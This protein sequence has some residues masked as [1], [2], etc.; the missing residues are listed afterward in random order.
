MKK[1]AIFLMTTILC[2]AFWNSNSYA[3]KGKP[4]LPYG[5]YSV[6]K[7][8][9][10]ALGDSKKSQEFRRLLIPLVQ[11]KMNQCGYSFTLKESDI[12]WIFDQVKEQEVWLES[13]Q[14]S[15]SR[16]LESSQKIE[17][18]VS[19]SRY[20][21]NAGVFVYENCSFPLYKV[22]CAN[23]LDAELNTVPKIDNNLLVPEKVQTVQGKTDT[24]YKEVW[25]KEPKVY[26][27]CVVR[28]QMD[29]GYGMQYQTMPVFIPTPMYMPMPSGPGY[30]NVNID[31]SSYYYNNEVTN[32]TNN[33]PPKPKPDPVD[34]GGPAPVPGHTD[35][36]APAPGHDDIVTQSGPGNSR[37]VNRPNDLVAS[38]QAGQ[39]NQRS[40]SSSGQTQN[41]KRSTTPYIKDDVYTTAEEKAQ[42][43]RRSSANRITTNPNATKQ[44]S[45]NPTRS[46]PN[47]SRATNTTSRQNN[48]VAQRNGRTVE[49]GYPGRN[50][51]TPNLD[52]YVERGRSNSSY[53]ASQ[54]YN[55]PTRSNYKS[56]NGGFSRSSG[57]SYRSPQSYRQPGGSQPQPRHA[58]SGSS[59][60]HRPSSGRR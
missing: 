35:G 45:V 55:A 4:I 14:F 2:F 36:P 27:E 28:V 31:N 25:V 46:N 15:N 58:P 57:G 48:L 26:E 24:V 33:Y 11:K 30:S 56:S 54:K 21:G 6:E 9:A 53:G 18:F 42:D 37:N 12:P 34:P 3:Q 1:F 43:D 7:V 16:W 29:M 51:S 59:G 32:I 39:R 49:R 13:R 60:G 17:F 10:L 38:N 19:E 22:S 5:D 50:S 52:K 8:K 23:L 20:E 47:G 41:L 40:V 44:G